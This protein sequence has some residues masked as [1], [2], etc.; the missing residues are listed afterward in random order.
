MSLFLLDDQGTVI[1][2]NERGHMVEDRFNSLEI[3]KKYPRARSTSASFTRLML[4]GGKGEGRYSL[5]DVDRLGVYT[6]VTGSNTGWV[7]GVS[8]PL[9]GTPAAQVD[10]LLLLTALILLGLGATA[11]FFASGLIARPFQTIEEQNR[12]LAE[13]NEIAQSAS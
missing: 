3:V 4:Q 2:N 1:A 7:L 9:Q 8:A 5:F 10:R 12:H 13:L 6:D 11:A